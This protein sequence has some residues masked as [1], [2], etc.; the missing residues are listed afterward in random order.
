MNKIPGSQQYISF[1]DTYYNSFKNLNS[2]QTR[3]FEIKKDH[4]FRVADLMRSIAELIEIENELESLVYITGLYHDIGRFSQFVKFGTF[5]DNVSIDHAALSVEVLG[6]NNVIAGLGKE[7]KEAVQ[8]AIFY[9]NKWKVPLSFSQKV[10]TLAYLLRDADKLDILAVL[11][12]YYE[13]K[14]KEPNHTLT[15]ELPDSHKI[16]EEVSEI[17]LQKKQLPKDIVKNE[18]DLKVFQMSWAY[19]LNFKSSFQILLQ[20]RYIKRIYNTLPKSEK[21]IEFYRSIKIFIE[22]QI[23]A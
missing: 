18:L 22:N 13:N 6:E 5:N 10:K 8:T 15:W 12:D 17:I 7:N 2:E 19:D 21:I 4:S 9:H 23:S 3:N 1:F 16:S 20:K 11:C 14:S